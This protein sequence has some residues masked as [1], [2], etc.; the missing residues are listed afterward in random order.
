MSEWVFILTP[1][2]VLPI[3]LL[4]RFVG[5]TDFERAPAPKAP[6]PTGETPPPSPP[7]VEGP[8]VPPAPKAPRYR[9]YIMGEPNNPGPVKNPAFVPDAASV[10]A[11]W[12]LTDPAAAARAK[13]EKGIY[14]GAYVT[15]ATPLT[16][17]APT[18]SQG[19]SEA[20]PGDFLTGQAGLI[21]S[22][23]TALCRFFNGG[24]VRVAF[25]PG[26][27]TDQFT[28]EAW[29]LPRPLKA[30][31]E[32]VL[33]DAGGR[34]GQ[35]G[36]PTVQD[37]GFRVFEDRNGCWQVR[38][39]SGTGALFPSPPLIPRP[40]RTHFALT[41]ENDGPG[42]VKKKAILYLD[43]KLAWTVSIPSYARPDGA[44]LFIGIENTALALT[45]PETF[46]HPVLSH[47][48]EVVLHNKPL[49][50]EEI[51]NHV[52]INKPL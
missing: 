30:G 44:P 48:Q 33:F 19:G 31:Y 13:D 37:R 2:L 12:R 45:A 50:R 23:P 17:I 14:P 24:H 16:H 22:E 7:V 36:G 25:K 52:D 28:I 26:L 1:V 6:T 21:A 40:G 20:A 39:L 46:Q 41:V 34:Y 32:H 5:C 29:V 8:S 47:V 18:G 38:L 27:Y 15:L 42:G 3:I 49:S 10:V 9:G 35:P 43:G 51:E 11:Y 4:F